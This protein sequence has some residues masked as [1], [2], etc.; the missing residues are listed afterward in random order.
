MKRLKWILATAALMIG[1]T[2]GAFAEQQRWSDPRDARSP[3]AQTYEGNR[4]TIRP[5]LE[6]TATAIVTA[7]ATTGDTGASGYNAKTGIRTDPIAIVV[8]ADMTATDDSRR[9]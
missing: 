6:M 1:I 2:G 7:T 9:S 8:T 5:M 4:I 3:Y